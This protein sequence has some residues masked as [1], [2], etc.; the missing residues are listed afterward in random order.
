MT[1]SI[2]SLDSSAAVAFFCYYLGHMHGDLSFVAW[3]P[4]ILTFSPRKYNVFA[5]VDDADEISRPGRH[6]RVRRRQG[7]EQA[8]P[9]KAGK[10]AVGRRV[11]ER[12]S[13]ARGLLRLFRF[14]LRL[15][16]GFAST[17]S[18]PAGAAYSI[19]SGKPRRSVRES[20]FLSLTLPP[21]PGDMTP[22]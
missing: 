15:W 6:T 4:F 12:F 14:R 3:M 13:P 2:S 8:R 16:L 10:R 17:A 1:N 20:R 18:W 5:P 9:V 7:N 22:R 11:P 21:R 19:F